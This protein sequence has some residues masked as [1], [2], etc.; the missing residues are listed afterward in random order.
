MYKTVALIVAGGRGTRLGAS[1]PKQYLKIFDENIIRKTLKKFVNNP[2]IDAVKVVIHPDDI[3]LYKIATYGLELLDPVFGGKSRQ[4]SVRAGLD[5]LVNLKPKNIIIHDAV[6]PFV[7]DILINQI[8][9]ELKEHNSVCPALP[10]KDSVKY[11]TK[12]PILNY[13]DKTNELQTNKKE[14][15]E[16]Y[17]KIINRENLVIL[18]TPQGFNFTELYKAYNHLGQDISK[19]TDDTAIIEQCGIKTK[20][21]TGDEH[22][23]KITSHED[24]LKAVNFVSGNIF[25]FRSGIGFDAH[26]F[27]PGEGGI[28]L[29]GVNIP[30][31]KIVEAHSDGDVLLH[32]IT[33]ALLGAI[34]LGDIGTHFPATDPKWSNASSSLFIKYTLEL[35]AKH[36]YEIV[37]IDTIIICEEPKI[38]RFREEIIN[39]L[40]QILE[41]DHKRLNLKA[42]T[43]EKMGFLGRKEGIA[44]QVSAMVK[45]Y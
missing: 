20:L 37:N 35:L 16:E 27:I 33:D 9:Q 11:I 5:S 1:L 43:T 28:M 30:H 26:K 25:E 2:N 32:A 31:D 40:A 17:A 29:G 34:G 10:L 7:S 15:C 13:N 42:T 45:Y 14:E 36:N 18:Q 41:I 39:S 8:V 23:F 22:N 4:E 6:R 19:H 21:I 44:A 24:L 3:E 38:G 12:N